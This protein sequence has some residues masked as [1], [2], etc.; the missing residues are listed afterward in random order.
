MR[1]FYVETYSKA[2]AKTIIQ[3][4]KKWVVNIWINQEKRGEMLRWKTN[5]EQVTLQLCK[6]RTK[7]SRKTN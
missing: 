5:T 2:Q 4:Q 3:V 7:I 1:P 6:K